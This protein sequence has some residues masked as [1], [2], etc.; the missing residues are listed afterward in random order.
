ML[1]KVLKFR[2]IFLVALLLFQGLL[3]A[4]HSL[5][6][7]LVRYEIVDVNCDPNLKGS[8]PTTKADGTLR[9]GCKHLGI[10]L[11]EFRV[12]FKATNKAA[13]L[14][15]S[16]VDVGIGTEGLIVPTLGN[17]KVTHD[18]GFVC[19][20]HVVIVGLIYEPAKVTYSLD[21]HDIDIHDGINTGLVGA[22]P[23]NYDGVP[24]VSEYPFK[25]HCVPA[26]IEVEPIHR[27]NW[28]DYVSK[29]CSYYCD[30][31]DKL[32]G[33]DPTSGGDTD[34]INSYNACVA[35]SCGDSFD[36]AGHANKL[37]PN[38]NKFCH[39]KNNN[40]FLSVIAQCVYETI[41]N[42]TFGQNEGTGEL[43]F[44]ELQN[45]LRKSV[46]ALLVLHIIFV[47]YD[48][49]TQKRKLSL[50][51]TPEIYWI[52]LKVAFVLYF[53]T[54]EG[55]IEFVLDGT[56][57]FVSF[58]SLLLIDATRGNPADILAA[59]DALNDAVEIANNAIAT[60]DI[61]TFETGIDEF[62]QPA[63]VN[64]NKHPAV[65]AAIEEVQLL[66][67]NYCNYEY[68]AT[69]NPHITP[70][71]P[72]SEYLRLWDTIDCKIA[73]YL[74]IGDNPA[75]KSTPQM[76]IL[77]LASFFTAFGIP[78]LILSIIYMVFLF[79]VVMRVI[80]I[81]LI[82]I[83]ALMILLFISPL[84]IP[85]ALFKF[86]KNIFDS[87]LNQV[88]AYMLQPIIILA[89]FSFVLALFDFA[90]FEDNY[91]FTPSHGTVDVNYNGADDSL[92]ANGSGTIESF[93]LEG[94]GYNNKITG[95]HFDTD[96]NAIVSDVVITP[97]QGQC[98]DEDSIACIYQSIKFRASEV[99]NA[100][101]AFNFTRTN[102]THEQS[103]DVASDLLLLVLLCFIINAAMGG[104]ESLST[105][106]TN[107]AAGGA[108]GMAS[109]RVYSPLQLAD[110]TA[111][112]S[113][114]K[115]LK[116]GKVYSV[117]RQTRRE[118]RNI[119]KSIS[120]GLNDD[121]NLLSPKGSLIGRLKTAKK[122]LKEEKKKKQ[123]K[124]D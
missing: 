78:I 30:K 38:R 57:N 99:N 18:K 13:G 63:I 37:D 120:N 81:Y 21:I 53:A 61:S 44:V 98:Y 104:V 45:D 24:Q 71:Q 114:L 72:G 17:I 4:N 16:T 65:I 96:T 113:E 51:K 91:M 59:N 105:R 15:S 118:Y 2:F 26:P 73:K 109:S 3:C 116:E 93:E 56:R 22:S 95:I 8:T 92:D 89:F 47:G 115:Q 110:G 82:S 64:L 55:I 14:I 69:L 67:Y 74:G 94:Y 23:V 123:D 97:D 19:I 102:M 11:K 117:V 90:I 80:E 122:E 62:G 119:R 58:M 85:A 101:D 100:G 29:T 28:S 10:G 121:I 108:A 112:T 43:F 41:E 84:T 1:K 86:T 7:L 75:N 34:K 27:I 20:E 6:N 111:L 83:V 42:L 103:R 79:L 46:R 35:H 33:L 124:N 87:W 9:Y 54:G 106:L 12:K 39:S 107:A 32:C 60:G 50:N 31:C 25:K 76:L 49:I 70:Y 77:S 88:I 5:A 66:G 68:H 40:P 36:L 52:F 48:I